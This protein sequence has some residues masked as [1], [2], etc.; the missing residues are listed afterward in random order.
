MAQDSTN[1]PGSIEGRE[2]IGATSAG[3]ALMTA[4]LWGGTPVAISYSVDTLP[5]IATAGLR[6]AL[7]SVFM[8][9]WCRWES[10]ELR[11]RAGQLKPALVAGV[12]LFVQIGLFHYGI[13]Q[14]NSSHGSLLINT[15]VIWV[16]AIDHFITKSDRLTTWRTL[17]L[18]L[19]ASGV[20]LVLTTTSAP[21]SLH[22]T[23]GEN[24]VPSLTGDLILLTSAFLLGVKIV[25]TKHALRTVEPSKLIFWHDVVG[26]AL[27][28]VYSASF[29]QTAVNDFSTPAVCG[30]LY[31]G[32]VVAGLCFAVQTRL[33]GRHSASRL[34]VFAFSTP[35]F[36]LT[37][38]FL[39]RGDPLSP[40]LAVSA[41]CVA[42][43]ILMVNLPPAATTRPQ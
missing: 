18:A 29:E 31:Q 9:F 26:M 37:F 21:G 41:A 34:S 43:G 16:V 3:L 17:G 15:F 25:Y 24:D 19:A 30:L 28:A 13:Q 14:S 33:L 5:P 39:F 38:A 27:L 11:L 36:G 32:L 40:W 7:A 22:S 35:L 23:A 4:A 2:P 8:V 20:A 6:F 10:T 42:T 1:P 12:L